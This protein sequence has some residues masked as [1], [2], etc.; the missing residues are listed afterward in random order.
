M[1]DVLWRSFFDTCARILGMGS[2]NAWQSLSWCSWTTFDRLACDAGYWTCGF[3]DSSELGESWIADGGTWGQPFAYYQ[4]AHI[5]VPARFYWE[6]HCADGFQTGTKSQPIAEL[7][8]ALLDAGV[9]HRLTE[10]VLEI[11]LY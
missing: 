4:L 2:R 6:R 7:S 3:P 5:I 10:A 8:R 11:K 9:P 1:D